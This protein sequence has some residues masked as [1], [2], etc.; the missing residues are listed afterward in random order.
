MERNQYRGED[1]RYQGVLHKKS[2]RLGSWKKRYY[3]LENGV[4]SWFKN[5]PAPNT[6][7]A[8][9]SGTFSEPTMESC[10]LKVSKRFPNYFAN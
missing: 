4:L 9:P 3:H 6:T 7:S 5:I 8:K 1:N 2:G 10:I